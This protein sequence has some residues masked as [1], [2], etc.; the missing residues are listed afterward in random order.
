MILIAQT[1]HRR[2][3]KGNSVP[4]G[5]GVLL[6]IENSIDQRRAVLII[7]ENIAKL[8]KISLQGRKEFQHEDNKFIYCRKA[9]VTQNKSSHN[10]NRTEA[11]FQP[12]SAL[13]KSVIQTGHSINFNN[14][15]IL[16]RDHRPYRLLLTTKSA[17]AQYLCE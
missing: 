2:R 3:E 7:C 15:K 14:V 5:Q 10:S 8:E 4:F 9:V 13:S 1:R 16:V 11:E 12:K 17:F 6:N